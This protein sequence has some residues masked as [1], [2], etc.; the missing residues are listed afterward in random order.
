MDV[1]EIAVRTATAVAVLTAATVAVAAAGEGLVG[2]VVA[3]AAGLLVGPA[4]GPAVGL[5]VEPVPMGVGVS[6]SLLPQ[7]T[8][9]MMNRPAI[10]EIAG[11]R[12][13]QF[14]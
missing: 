6:P 11:L 5:L 12:S 7:A 3:P 9:K 8:A 10:T 1:A 4:V 13:R 2:L 14:L